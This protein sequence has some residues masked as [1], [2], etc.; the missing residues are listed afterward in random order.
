MTRKKLMAEVKNGLDGNNIPMDETTQ[1]AVEVAIQC[2]L[3][4]LLNYSTQMSE[5]LITSKLHTEAMTAGLVSKKVKSLM[6][7]D[8]E[9]A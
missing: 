4:Y 6:G 2:T 3:Q 1:A 8:E 5:E 7:N 9:S